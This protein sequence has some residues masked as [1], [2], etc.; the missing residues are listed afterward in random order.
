MTHSQSNHSFIARPWR[1]IWGIVVLLVLAVG[2]VKFVFLRGTNFD[3]A[4]WRDS[5][6]AWDNSR[7]QMAR[8]LLSRGELN[9]KTRSDVLSMLGQPNS[10]S[11]V[12]DGAMREWNAD[13]YFVGPDH[14]PLTILPMFSPFGFEWMR[15]RYE[16]NGRVVG[17]ELYECSSAALP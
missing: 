12:F 13:H 14:G 17:A 6:S 3:A 16:G 4:R 7:L 11:P 5:A 8:R 9:G 10:T 1:F 2:T 15:V